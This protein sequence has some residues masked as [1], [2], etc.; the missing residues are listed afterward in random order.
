MVNICFAQQRNNFSDSILK[1]IPNEKNNLKKA[2]LYKNLVAHYIDT[3]PE[4]AIQFSIKGLQFSEKS[5]QSRAIGVFSNFLGTIYHRQGDF[6]KSMFYFKKSYEINK[7]DSDFENL[8]STLNNLGNLYLDQS[9]YEKAIKNYFEAIKIAEKIKNNKLISVCLGNIGLVFSEQKNYKKALFYYTKSLQLNKKEKDIENTANT[10]LLIANLY[11]NKKDTIQAKKKYLEA[12]SYFKKSKRLI[13]I[14]T[15]Y[16]NISILFKDLNTNVRYKLLAQQIWNKT[17]SKNQ[18]SI[19]NLG[20]L[21]FEFLRLAKIKKNT[22]TK[23]SKTIP[24]NRNQLLEM[25]NNFL[26]QAFSLLGKNTDHVNFAFLKGIKSELETEKGN[27]KLAYEAIKVHYEINDSIFSQ[28]NKNK[29]AAIENQ[30]EIDLKNHQI[31]LNVFKLKEK[32]KQKW[33]Y[34]SGIFLIGI[35]GS[36]IYIQS[37]NRQ[38]VNQKLQILNKKLDLKNIALDEANKAKTRF[39]SILN[40]DLRSPVSNLIDFLHLQKDSP[41]LLD[42]DTKNRIGSATLTAAENL[43]NSMEDILQWS[44]S[45]MENFKPQPKIMT[46]NLLFE[47]LKNHFSSEE[48]VQLIFENPENIQINTDENYLKTIIRNLTG[49]AIKSLSGIENPVIIWKAW[50][51][52]GITFLSISDNGK[53]ASDEQFKALYDDKEV[54]GIKTGLG[55]HLIRDLAKAIECEISVHSKEN[56]GT[57]FTLK[58]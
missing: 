33:F 32:E 5:K 13:E 12:L 58:L 54:G 26:N 23:F 6:K 45:Q 1:L 31:Q 42:D 22:T 19:V 38:K 24:Y 20:N 17:G 49:N 46:L 30:K 57:T 29:I 51:E 25:S 10:T 28:E 43:L 48:K 39:F 9:E 14:A 7:K 27:Y 11:S 56:E 34:I 18:L 37:R 52:N 50:Q 41:D 16:Q 47:D 55:L 2:R 53:G 15:T 8:A 36:L 40:H 44:K 21:A 3:E 4:K 35:I